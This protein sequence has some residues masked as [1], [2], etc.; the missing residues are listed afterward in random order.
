MG[1]KKKLLD[2]MFDCVEPSL[3]YFHIIHRGLKFR[4][5]VAYTGDN[6]LR[7]TNRAMVLC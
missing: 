1:L 5:Y 2:F 4:G 3:G 7:S 6:F